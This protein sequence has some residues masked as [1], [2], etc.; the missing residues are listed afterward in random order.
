MDGAALRAGQQVV[1]GEVVPYHPGVQ[2]QVQ[3]QV[4]MQVQVQ[5]QVQVQLRSKKYILMIKKGQ[6]CAILPQ[7]KEA[8]WQLWK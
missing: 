1:G 3:V 7:K 5:V 6:K 8:S 2:V 4:Q